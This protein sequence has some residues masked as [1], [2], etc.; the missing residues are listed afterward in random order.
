MKE[1]ME[2]L[3]YELNEI[4]EVL[5]TFKKD[6]PEDLHKILMDLNIHSI[7]TLKELEVLIHDI[8]AKT[9]NRR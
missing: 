4:N 1:V 6:I 7:N 8:C 9:G 2:D 3:Q 5:K